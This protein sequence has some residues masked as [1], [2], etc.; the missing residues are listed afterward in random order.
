MNSYGDSL[1][2]TSERYGCNTN[3][4]YTP[5]DPKEAAARMEAYRLWLAAY[6]ALSDEQKD[7]WQAMTGQAKDW[8][9]Q[10]SPAEFTEFMADLSR[11]IRA[12]A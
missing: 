1:L 3:V 2:A 11:P 7:A 6:Y 10:L 12:A 4:P 8:T 9:K 5:V